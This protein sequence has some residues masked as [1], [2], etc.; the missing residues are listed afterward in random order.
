MGSGGRDLKQK[1]RVAD[2]CLTRLLN[3]ALIF[4][5]PLKTESMC[6]HSCVRQMTQ[7]KPEFAHV[8]DRRA[9]E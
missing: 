4:F 3:V 8:A 6:H 9:E 1:T 5:N 2:S 7:T